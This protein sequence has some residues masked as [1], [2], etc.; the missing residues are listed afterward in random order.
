[1]CSSAVSKI[2]LILREAIRHGAT[3]AGISLQYTFRV[4]SPCLIKLAFHGADTDTDIVADGHPREDRR[5]NV[6]VSF[7]LP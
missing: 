3:R 1:M 4:C 6:G 7:G 5:E 2:G